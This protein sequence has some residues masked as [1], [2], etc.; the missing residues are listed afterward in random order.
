MRIVGHRGFE[1]A[2]VA[3]GLALLWLAIHSVAGLAANVLMP[4]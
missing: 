3:G 4:G 1:A 2:A